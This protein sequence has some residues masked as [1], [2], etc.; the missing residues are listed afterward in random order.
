MGTCFYV[1]GCMCMCVRPDCNFGYHS[2]F[3]SYF[4]LFETGPLTDLNHSK[5]TRLDGH[6]LCHPNL[7]L[8]VGITTYTFSKRGAQDHAL[9]IVLAK[10]HF[11]EQ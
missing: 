6:C 7:G 3:V 4:Y 8:Q 11:T 9:A 5:N 10:Q 1:Y 2:R